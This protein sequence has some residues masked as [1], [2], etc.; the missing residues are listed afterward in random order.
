VSSATLAPVRRLL[1]LLVA[2]VGVPPASA[3]PFT[4][5]PSPTIVA[6][7]FRVQARTADGPAVLSWEGPWSYAERRGTSLARRTAIVERGGT[8]Y[9]ARGG[10]SD[11]AVERRIF[12]AR[13]E[14]FTYASRLSH[15]VEYVLA[16]ARGGNRAFRV[17][18]LGG[19]P[20]WSTVVGLKA[21]DC[22]GLRR[23]RATLWLSP[24]TLL[25]LRVVE[26]RGRQTRVFRYSYSSLNADLPAT[27]F[28]R[29]PL[30]RRPTLIDQRFRRTSKGDAA[31]H[32]SY[33][34]ELPTVL[35]PGFSLALTGWAPRSAHTG[36]EGS[37]P[38]KPQLF[39]ASYRRGFERIDVTQ[40]LSGPNG[41]TG[42]PFGGE[43]L[44][45]YTEQVTVQGVQGTYGIG[46]EIVPHVYWREGNVLYTVSGP[47]PR[48][49]LVAIA[50]SLAP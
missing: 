13:P 32:L 17:A 33:T 46:A 16:Q 35:P 10:G 34:P 41:W 49:D 43:C 23:G 37:I 36:A 29:P 15:Y 9:L 27:D 22:A 8:R 7:S 39:A 42:D 12:R 40:R 38:P 20:A 47:F 14:G 21:N 50:N 45:E 4:G 44:F 31:G 19:Q 48:R 11:G 3:Q 25:P 24:S 5:G 26:R 18:T 1:V 6:T 28:A 30:G 2:L